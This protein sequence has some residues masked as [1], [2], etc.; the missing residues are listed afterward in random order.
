[1][2][3]EIEQHLAAGQHDRAFDLV[4]RAYKDRVFRLAVSILKERAAAEDAAG[5]AWLFA[6]AWA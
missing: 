4:V 2:D 1:M 6:G 3:P 5:A